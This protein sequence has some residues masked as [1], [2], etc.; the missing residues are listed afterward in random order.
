MPALTDFRV[1]TFDCYGTLIDWETGILSSLGRVVRDHR[2]DLTDDAVL[3]AYAEIEA[4][5]ERG[6][7]V[8]YREILA[9]VVRGFGERFGFAPTSAELSCLADSVGDWPPF[10]DT[11]PA[12][13]ALG[14]RYRLG[15]V[16]NV[17]ND[18]FALTADRLDTDF[19]WVVTAEDVRSYKPCV[20]NFEHAL[21]RIALPH[22]R[23][24]HVAQS[25]YHDIAPAREAGL[26]TVWVNRRGDRGGWGATPASRAR[27]DMEVRSL[28]GL[29]R[30]AGLG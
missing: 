12:L 29:V 3:E 10:S 8:R 26:K 15:I 18:L 17:D 30:A 19:E 24:L 28:A 25:L 13:R 27:P 2:P 20:G 7:Y 1:L 14:A 21:K 22:E 5:A 6:T 16:S 11:V 23:V 4:A 9:G